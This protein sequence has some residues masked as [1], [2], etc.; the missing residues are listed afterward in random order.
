MGKDRAAA[1]EFDHFH[2]FEEGDP[3]AR[4]EVLPGQEV[5]VAG[6]EPDRDP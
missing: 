5:M 2:L 6:D 3:G 1:L 4:R